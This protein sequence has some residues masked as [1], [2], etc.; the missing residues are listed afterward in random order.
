MGNFFFLFH[1]PK[2]PARG[3]NRLLIKNNLTS[4]RKITKNIL[5]ILII[6]YQQQ[7]NKVILF[8]KIF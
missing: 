6:K 3:S 5:N 7:F 2:S 8:N 4:I 1:L